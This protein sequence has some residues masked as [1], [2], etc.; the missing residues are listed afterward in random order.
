[1]SSY[2]I[3]ILLPCLIL[4]AGC[5]SQSWSSKDLP[6]DEYIQVY[7]N[8]RQTENRTY[9]DPYRQI[10]RQGDDLEAVII[11]SIESA[12]SS[13]DLAVQELKLPQIALALVQS[14]LSGVKIRV[15][16]D[17]NYSRPLSQLSSREVAKLN[18]RDRDRYRDFLL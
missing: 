6:Q 12:K 8:H 11:E 14:H 4:F 2:L 18:K 15:I 13:I 10:E 17:N 1:M 5:Q 7:F 9:T 3:S 16:L